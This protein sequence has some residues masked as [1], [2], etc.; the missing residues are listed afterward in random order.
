MDSES[1]LLET[2]SSRTEK[3]SNRPSSFNV[4]T[5]NKPRGDQSTAVHPVFPVVV[6]L[7][8]FPLSGLNL[9]LTLI[10][11]HKLHFLGA[12]ASSLRFRRI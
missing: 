8:V 3:T 6:F 10:S 11:H 5:E 9:P 1:R 7:P 12:Q 2:L 4:A